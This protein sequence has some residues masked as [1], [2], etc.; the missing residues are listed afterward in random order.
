MESCQQTFYSSLTV[1]SYARHLNTLTNQTS[2]LTV[3][4]WISDTSRFGILS[5]EWSV[6]NINP[7]VIPCEM[8]LTVSISPTFSYCF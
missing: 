4:G 5:A 1:Q 7:D 6:E 3:L 2:V 8:W